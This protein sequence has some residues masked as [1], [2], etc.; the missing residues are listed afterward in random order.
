M[1][2]CS[3]FAPSTTGQAHP[4]TLLAALLCWLDAR[5]R[6]A[7]LLLRLEDVDHTRSRPELSQ[8]MGASLA[9]FGL[10]WDEV[11]EQSAHRQRHEQALDALAA[12]GRLYP[13]RCSRADRRRSGRRAPDGG[14]AYDN[15]CRERPLPAGGWRASGDN[16]RARLDDEAIA[17][18]DESGFDLS[19]RPAHDMGDPVVLRRD[20][21]IAYHLAVVVDDAA[22]GVTRVVRGRDLAASTATQVA[23][24]RLLGVP[25]PQY[26]HH[27]LLLEPHGGKLAKFHGAVGVDA[28]APHYSAPALCGVLAHA[29]GLRA[30]PAPCRPADLVSDFD[31]GRVREDDRVMAWRAPALVLDPPLPPA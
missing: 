12:Q 26:R 21:A 27:M 13:C 17:L 29:A 8:A 2:D 7:R 31:W 11:H 16:L 28:L 6:G 3:R 10:D 22:A 24:Q 5:A 25:T 18:R 30:S 20:G 1:R 15:A 19:Q 4:G 9:W 23:L 14:F